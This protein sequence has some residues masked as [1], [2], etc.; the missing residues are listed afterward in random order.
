MKTYRVAILCC[1]AT[2]AMLAYAQSADEGYQTATVL[3]IEK[4]AANAQHME[5]GD[6][7]K[8]SMR[9]GDTIYLCKVSAPSP[10]FMEWTSGKEFPAKEDGK[11][12]HVKNKDGKI[13]D[14][15]IASKKKPK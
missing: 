2:A 6:R 7:F 14:L 11:V 15:N 3:S 8:I 4:L 9:M 5:E 10:L 1:I 12:L 13:V